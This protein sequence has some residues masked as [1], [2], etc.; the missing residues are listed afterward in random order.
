MHV[1]PGQRLYILPCLEL[2]AYFTLPSDDQLSYKQALV[3]IAVLVDLESCSSQACFWLYFRPKFLEDMRWTISLDQCSQHSASLLQLRKQQHRVK[4]AS[5]KDSDSQAQALQAPSVQ[6]IF[7]LQ[8]GG[9]IKTH[10]LRRSQA[11]LHGH[12]VQED[13]RGG[14]L[15]EATCLQ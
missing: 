9:C 1:W 13:M 6:H 10:I 3:S 2:A 8:C 12:C 11:S 5:G 14:N 15:P 7:L 4:T